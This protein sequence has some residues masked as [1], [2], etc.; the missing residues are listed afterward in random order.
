MPEKP[1]LIKQTSLA[2]GSTASKWQGWDLKE[3]LLCLQ[4]PLFTHDFE[5]PKAYP[6]LVATHSLQKTAGKSPSFN[7]HFIEH[8]E[9]VSHCAKYRGYKGE[10]EA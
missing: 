7:R 3:G 2:Q 6:P 10:Q 8:L 9:P 1:G 4:R 5:T